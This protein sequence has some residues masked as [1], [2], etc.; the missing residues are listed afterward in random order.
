MI[1]TLQLAIASVL[2]T[3][4]STSNPANLAYDMSTSD[5]I[6]FILGPQ[7]IRAD[8][9]QIEAGAK[10]DEIWTYVEIPSSVL[11]PRTTEDTLQVNVDGIAIAH[12]FFGDNPLAPATAGDFRIDFVTS[13]TATTGTIEFNRASGG[14]VYLDVTY[15]G[16]TTAYGPPLSVIF[17]ISTGFPI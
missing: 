12:E 5:S 10:L 7:G 6:I 1:K 8:L 2:L 15:Q 3:A 11:D 9:P 16:T 4:C 17:E 14:A 13:P